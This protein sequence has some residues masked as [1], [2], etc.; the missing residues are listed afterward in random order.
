MGEPE[1]VTK[2]YDS[3]VT[4]S[5]TIGE[6]HGSIQGLNGS[7]QSLETEIKEVKQN[8]EDCPA[9]LE[10]AY[11][12]RKRERFGKQLALVGVVS[13]TIGGVVGALISILRP[14]LEHLVHK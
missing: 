1:M 14:L 6:L 5:K 10:Y 9:R 8:Q 2:L 7:I 3:I 12:Q 13:S 11:N 4:M